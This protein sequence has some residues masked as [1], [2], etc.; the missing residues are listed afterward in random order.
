[1]PEFIDTHCHLA[2]RRLLR[3]VP[4]VLER[5]AQ[6]G[7]STVICASGELEEA[8]QCRK[9]AADYHTVY[10]TAGV[11]PHVAKDAPDGY[12]ETLRSLL[13]D[14]K[15]LAVGECGLDYYYDL[16]P[17]PVQRRVFAEQLQLARQERRRVVI[18]TREAFADTLAVLRESGIDGSMVVFHS[19]AQQQSEDLAAA[20]DIGAAIG[21][22][23]I[24]TF[25]KSHTLRSA[26]TAVPDDRILIETDSPYLS[27]E[28]VR[29]SKT[30]EP[31]NVRH[32]AECL[33]APRGVTLDALA[34][35]TTANARRIFGLAD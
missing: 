25:A 17:R 11:H 19:F 15:C 1:M 20:L 16:S 24:V 31:A 7:V 35:L 10:F 3:Q 13:K 12:V 21:F 26:A 6:A 27:P 32:V 14:P 18:H 22:S 5:A 4:A 33:A 23:G 28:P 29:R 34:R 2:H 9:L 30:N 8:Q